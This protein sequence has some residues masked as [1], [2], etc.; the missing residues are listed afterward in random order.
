MKWLQRT[1]KHRHVACAPNGNLLR[2]ARSSGFQT[3]CAHRL[4]VFVP[5]SLVAWTFW[6]SSAFG[7]PSAEFAK[8]NQEFAQ[9]HFKEAIAGYEALV[10]AGQWN[11]N[12]FYDLG[13][14]YF[15]TRDFGR[16]I[17]N[18]ERAL[19][20]DQH[21][22]EATANLQIARDEAR[23]LELQPTR[24]E[25]YL[26]FASI[27]QCSIAA[28]VALWLG[29]FGIVTWIFARRRS[30]ALMSLSILC[31]LVSAMAI[32]AIHTLDHGSKGRALA[33]VTGTDVQARL[34]TADTANSVL[35][36]PAGSEIKI[37]STRGDWM[38]AALPNDLRGWIQTKNTE[39]VRL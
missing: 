39:Q 12:L 8:A 20:L 23:A 28:A 9:G 24:L 21:H 2:C 1:S 25:R 29:I 37:L 32:W 15:R 35:A 5:I 30:T 19:A 18:Y 26:Q 31:L 38:Y 16:A 10:R 33:I 11:A 14:A 6:I 3:R 22:P 13:N 36:L 4:K 27:S 7:Q 34:A 17:L